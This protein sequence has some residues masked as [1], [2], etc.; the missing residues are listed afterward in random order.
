MKREKMNQK[1]SEE[2]I[3]YV[4][5]VRILAEGGFIEVNKDV[6]N[7]WAEKSNETEF[8]TL[9]YSQQDNWAVEKQKEE[10]LQ[11]NDN[12]IFKKIDNIQEF[13]DYIDSG[14]NREL[15]PVRDVGM[16][17]V[18]SSWN[19]NIVEYMNENIPSTK[20]QEMTKELIEEFKK[21]FEKEE[22]K[23]NEIS[24][25]ASN[26][27]LSEAF[28]KV[29]KDNHYD[30]AK[31]VGDEI[32]N[33]AGNIKSY[34][35]DTKDKRNGTYVSKMSKTFE[36]LDSVKSIKI[37]EKEKHLGDGVFQ[38][39]TI[40]E[41]GSELASSKNILSGMK[42]YG[43]ASSL[44]G[45]YDSID[46]LSNATDNLK[47]ELNTRNSQNKFEECIEDSRDFESPNFGKDMECIEENIKDSKADLGSYIDFATDASG[48]SELKES[49]KKIAGVDEENQN[50]IKNSSSE[51]NQEKLGEEIILN[52]ENTI[53]GL[54]VELKIEENNNLDT[55]LK[56][57]E[58]VNDMNLP[59]YDSSMDYGMEID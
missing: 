47:K 39:K 19:E 24:T 40:K 6:L 36:S 35:D 56:A 13:K 42:V 2:T 38:N 52:D 53:S 57:Q 43:A 41:L 54:S 51:K 31:F 10:L 30:E 44:Y 4:G 5:D 14:M 32:I 26:M 25:P 15:H 48:H 3:G 45:A 12:I 8:A 28:E 7:T 29:K 59:Q 20:D 50:N 34:V 21:E 17:N 9:F 37:P 33:T 18:N 16:V 49:L 46:K 58:I 1:N 27:T 11:I 23:I 55:T 22:N